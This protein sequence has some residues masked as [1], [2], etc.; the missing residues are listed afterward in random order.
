MEILT[1][2]QQNKV[3]FISFSLTAASIVYGFW[4]RNEKRKVEKIILNEAIE[5]HQN[6]SILLGEIQRAKT[7]IAQNTNAN[8]E[9]GKA[10]GLADGILHESAKLFCNMK[11]TSISDIEA[12]IKVGKLNPNYKHIYLSYSIL[13][14]SWFCK[15]F[16]NIKSER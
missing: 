6:V 7:N 2:I 11:Q 14:N 12:M 16:K 1:L 10:E 13:D 3:D 9:I 5:I 15:F 4:Q 8:F